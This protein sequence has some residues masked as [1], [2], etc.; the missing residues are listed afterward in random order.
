MQKIKKIVLLLAIAIMVLNSGVAQET[1][2]IKLFTSVVIEPAL[3]SSFTAKNP[4]QF[5]N[6]P[7]EIRSVPNHPEDTYAPASNAGP[8][9]VSS[10]NEAKLWWIPIALTPS[11][12]LRMKNWEIEGGIFGS[13]S[14]SK[15]E[16]MER[17]YTNAPGSTSRSTGAALTYLKLNDVRWS[18]GY[19]GSLRYVV[20]KDERKG[21]LSLL[22]LYKKSYQSISILTGWDRY[23]EYEDCNSFSL[24]TF[25]H[26]QLGIGP[27]WG[28]GTYAINAFAGYGWSNPASLSDYGKATTII[29]NRYPFVTVTLRIKLTKTLMKDIGGA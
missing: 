18:Y 28:D 25:A 27:E 21:G 9:E 11:I 6:I 8:I 24:G 4:F 12:G 16:R 20:S 19:F 22:L 7:L 10:L 14:I 23:S 29:T 15:H 5:Q 13:L 1:A 26:N 3:A 2:K 17:N